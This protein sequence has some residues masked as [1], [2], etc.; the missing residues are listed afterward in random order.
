MVL[1]PAC[2]RPPLAEGKVRFVGEA[3]AMVVAE[4][5]AAAVDAAE[6]VDVEYETLHAVV[7]L[8]QAVADGA[9]LQFEEIGT[10][11]VAGIAAADSDP[12]A[13][14][15]TVVRAT[16]QNQRVAVV[17][18]EGNAIA[19]VPGD[20][21]HG[22]DLTVY[23]STQ[24]PHGFADFGQPDPRP[25]RRPPCGWWRRTSAAPSAARPGW[26]TSTRR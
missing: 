19:V 17:P 11:L 10:N 15:T 22:H 2:A 8:E 12:L 14:A 13:G 23:V 9:P 24:M 21:G 4:T 5:K 20:D 6:L 1:N 16:L 26:A 3:V 7:D 18:M 25:R